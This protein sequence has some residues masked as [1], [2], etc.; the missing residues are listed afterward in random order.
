MTRSRALLALS[1]LPFLMGLDRPAG[2]GNVTEVRHWSYDEY[3][4]IVIELDRPVVIKTDVKRLPANAEAD[5]PERIYLDLDGIWVG[6]KY[7]SGIGVGDGLLYGVR[8]GQN[9]RSAIRVVVD[10]AR[11]ERHRVLTLSHPDRLVVDV[12]GSREASITESGHADGGE[13]PRLP[14]AFRAIQTVVLD[15]GHGGRD[16]GAIGVGGVREKDV[17][18][19]MARALEEDL[20]ERGF[21]VVLTRKNDQA[22]SLEERTAIAEAARG[23]LFVSLHANAA[24]RR[25]VRGVE[26]Y[27]LDENHERH[28]LTLA[29]RENGIARG[30]VNALQSTL[31]K[32]RVSEVSPQSRKLAETV[33]RHIVEG[34][35][36]AYDPVPDLGAKKGPFYVLFLSSMP[37]I[38]IEAGFLTNQHDAKRLR[39]DKYVS[40]MAE[41]IANALRT[42]RDGE[43]P[44]TVGRVR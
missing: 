5:R 10:L 27:Y 30:Q 21:E 3:T 9:T 43:T 24:P 13:L 35:P 39:D 40:A 4:R 2:L 31:A 34:M 38:L 25:A 8:I 1:V 42:Y 7:E 14:S 17:T 18:L 16:P 11:Y 20:R 15:P 26:T 19:S 44:V 36:S 41:Q 6:R 33:Q 32:L 12:Y 37:A 29:A 23:D 28:S 22:V